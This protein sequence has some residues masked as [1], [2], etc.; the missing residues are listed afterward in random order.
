MICKV[1]L[2]T[3]CQEQGEKISSF[4]FGK[5]VRREILPEQTRKDLTRE[6]LHLKP[7]EDKFNLIDIDLIR[8]KSQVK[9]NGEI[10]QHD[11]ERSMSNFA[12]SDLPIFE[13]KYQNFNIIK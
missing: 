12:G 2:T 7:L 13:N 11:E 5:V 3:E 9:F 1:Y 8:D 6:I 10:T 4:T